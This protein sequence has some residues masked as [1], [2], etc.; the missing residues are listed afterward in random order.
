MLKY[1]YAL[2]LKIII[3]IEMYP[4]LQFETILLIGTGDEFW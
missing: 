2:S 3:V 1:I 4:K